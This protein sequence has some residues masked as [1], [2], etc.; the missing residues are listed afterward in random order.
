[1]Q[2]ST[3]EADRRHAATGSDIYLES[4][5]LLRRYHEAFELMRNDFVERG[6]R[7]VVMNDGEG[8]G[9]VTIFKLDHDAEQLQYLKARGLLNASVPVARIVAAYKKARQK[10]EEQLAPCG[11]LSHSG[12]TGTVVDAAKRGKDCFPARQVST[13]PPRLAQEVMQQLSKPHHYLAGAEW[14][15]RPALN[16]NLD[17]AAIEEAYFDGIAVIDN[18]L[19]D[20]A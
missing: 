8:F 13:L 7:K 12:V 1:M 3:K 15:G 14:K 17:L 19:T 2:L 9:Q 11:D 18:F 20:E 4:L 6:P 10:F 5:K 16:P